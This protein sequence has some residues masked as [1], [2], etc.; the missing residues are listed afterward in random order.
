MIL[1]K[2]IKKAKKG[3]KSAFSELVRQNKEMMY[4]VAM[5]ILKNENDSLDAIQET[6]LVCWQSLPKLEKNKYFKTWLTKVLMNKC[7][8]IIR[9]NSRFLLGDAVPETGQEDDNDEKIIVN[10]I[11]SEMSESSR[12][13]LT[14]FYYEDLSVRDIS[15]V[16]GI[17]QGAVKTRLNRSRNQFK[18]IYVSKG[19]STNEQY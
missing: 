9:K 13:I 17:S 11:I 14:L 18:E 16:L 3:D 8:D 10:S 1:D 12:L 6:I 7:Y 4:N 5:N 2:L 15:E 19:G